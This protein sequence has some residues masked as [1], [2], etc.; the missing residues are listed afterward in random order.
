MM[1]NI[2][3]EDGRKYT[4]REYF[5]KVNNE[6]LFKIESKIFGHCITG[7]YDYIKGMLRKDLFSA[8]IQ[9]IDANKYGTTITIA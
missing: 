6:G 9:A 1:Q 7:E 3:N 4:L 8:C 5:E 2:Y